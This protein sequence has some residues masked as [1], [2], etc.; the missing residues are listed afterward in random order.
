MFRKFH[1]STLFNGA[2]SAVLLLQIALVEPT[3]QSS[4]STNNFVSSINA[5]CALNKYKMQRRLSQDSIKALSKAKKLKCLTCKKISKHSLSF[6]TATSEMNKAK[7]DKN[8]GI[9]T[10]KYIL[11]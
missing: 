5:Y 11:L 9:N 3:L 6:K 1:K 10:S 7:L 4:P 2:D 8:V